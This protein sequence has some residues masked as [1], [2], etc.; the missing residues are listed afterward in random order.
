VAGNQLK[1]SV[2]RVLGAK[3]RVKGL[4]ESETATDAEVRAM[5]IKLIR[6]TRAHDP[7][8]GYN[9]MPR[10]KPGRS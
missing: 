3:H 5:E 1:Q 4:L 6:E 9:V 10:W 8:I 2:L 7:A